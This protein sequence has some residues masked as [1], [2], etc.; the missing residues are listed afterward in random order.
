[1][2]DNIINAIF[3]SMMIITGILVTWSVIHE[4]KQKDAE[5][6]A[7]KYRIECEEYRADTL[8]MKLDSLHVLNWEN[9]DYWLEYFDIKHRDIVK[10][11]IILE[12]G[13]LTSYLCREQHNLF[14][15]RHPNVRETTSLGSA[16]GHAYYKNYIDSIKDYAI[17]QQYYDKGDYY[18]FLRDIG[19]AEAPNYVAMLKKTQI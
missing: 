4:D 13:G 1:M 15:M 8:Q 5:I 7:L 2:K 11:Q 3:M 16:Y 12:T 9:I 19:Y 18:A 14:G 10:K 17:W 6:D